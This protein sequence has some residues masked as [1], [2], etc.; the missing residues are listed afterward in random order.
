MLTSMTPSNCSTISFLLSLSLNLLF[1]VEK[2]LGMQGE[3]M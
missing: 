3:H 1:K 2:F